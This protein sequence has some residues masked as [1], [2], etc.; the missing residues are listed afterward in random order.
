MSKSVLQNKAEGYCYLCAL[1]D[2]DYSR[3]LYREE[4]HV[5]GGPLRKKSEHYGLKV[6][7]CAR[8]HCGDIT[9][10]KD[11]VHRPD[12][13]DYAIRLKKAAQAEFEKRYG[14]ELWMSEFGRNYL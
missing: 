9:G 1:I 7:L 11:A 14:H 13:N 2:G 4:H 5:F 6:Y 8:H 3:K 12:C 10:S